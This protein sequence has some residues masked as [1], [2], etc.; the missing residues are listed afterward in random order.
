MILQGH[1]GEGYTASP[2]ANHLWDPSKYSHPTLLISLPT[3]PPPH[4]FPIFS[5]LMQKIQ[6]HTQQP[7]SKKMVF[8]TDGVQD[9]PPPNMASWHIRY[10][11]LKESEKAAEARRSLWPPP[12]PL[13]SLKRVINLP[14]ERSLPCTRREEDILITRGREL[15]AEKSDK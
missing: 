1:G 3:G 7:L 13:L 12:S 10:L 2:T 5:F 8:Q 15:G 6:P 14:S 11:K 9:M 4:T